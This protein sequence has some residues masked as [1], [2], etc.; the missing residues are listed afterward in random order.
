[1]ASGGTNYH[2]DNL[3]VARDHKF[4]LFCLPKAKKHLSKI[5]IAERKTAI[6]DEKGII[7]VYWLIIF[8]SSETAY[9]I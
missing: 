5:V 7:L 4:M 2:T 9:W 8:K 3:P 6:N 1:M